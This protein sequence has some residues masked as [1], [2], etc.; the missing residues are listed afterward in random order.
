VRSADQH[1]TEDSVVARVGLLLAA[2]G[3]NDCALGV[4]ELARRT[5]L[6]KSTVHRLVQELVTR[7]LL[8]RDGSA[9]RL[10]MRLFEL[11]QL[12]PKQRT[13]RDASVPYM[14]DLREATRQTVSLAILEGHEVVYVEILRSSHG[15]ALP[16]RV[17]GRLPAHATGVG[18][19]ILAHSPQSVLDNAFGRPL[20]RL[21]P[22]TITSRHVLQTELE[23]IRTSGRG[24]DHE[25]SGHGIVCAASPVFGPGGIL[26]A[27]SVSGWSGRLDLQRV[28]PAVQTAAL[29]LS[30]TLTRDA[31]PAIWDPAEA[32]RRP[33]VPSP[34]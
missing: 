6:A 23:K 24:F 27:L 5:G 10:G 30:R 31:R 33:R 9:V 13:L 21:S 14:A 7:S 12:V 4:S 11:G 17:G 25:E 2:F 28:A 26:G 34:R 22:R 19:V 16:S 18:K 8:D 1:D 20:Q 3:P 29:A 15:P 32:P